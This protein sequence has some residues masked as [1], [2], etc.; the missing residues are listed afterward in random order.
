MTAFR[1]DDEVVHRG[2][3][4]RVRGISPMSIEPR[5]VQL[6]DVSTGEFVEVPLHEVRKVQ[7]SDD[8]ED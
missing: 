2:R 4:F 8:R 5:R 3:V 1:I 7:A 6:Q